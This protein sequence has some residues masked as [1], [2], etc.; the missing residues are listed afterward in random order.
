MST[1]APT[2]LVKVAWATFP[3]LR[4]VWK[5]SKVHLSVVERGPATCG[6]RKSRGATY[7]RGESDFT[8]HESEAGLCSKCWR[9]RKGSSR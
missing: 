5:P 2:G 9:P 4:G 1:P 7:A 6:A 3:S 8:E